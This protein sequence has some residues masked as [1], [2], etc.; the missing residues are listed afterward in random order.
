MLSYL[1][2]TRSMPGTGPTPEQAHEAWHGQRDLIF[3]ALSVMREQRMSMVQTVRQ[4]VFAY[5][6]VIEALLA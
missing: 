5:R 1:R 4:Y 6:A 3:E 2:N